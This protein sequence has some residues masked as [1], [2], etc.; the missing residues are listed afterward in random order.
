MVLAAWIRVPYLLRGK[1]GGPPFSSTY[2]NTGRAQ[3]ALG[4]LNIL[5][6][7][8]LQHY[9]NLSDF[10]FRAGHFGVPEASALQPLPAPRHYPSN[11]RERAWIYHHRRRALYWLFRQA[12]LDH[13]EAMRFYAIYGQAPN[14]I[15]TVAI[16]NLAQLTRYHLRR[17]V[18]LD[19]SRGQH[20]LR[21]ERYLAQSQAGRG[22]RASFPPGL[23]LPAELLERAAAETAA[24][25]GEVVTP[26]SGIS[27]FIALSL[28]HI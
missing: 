2:G 24:L 11:S 25:Q 15:P 4:P 23:N 9:T 12:G 6:R 8:G 14:Y 18:Q 13:E 16:D 20:M 26:A 21:W 28:I 10:K 19:F 5:L 17:F 27:R 1:L 3:G 7:R 22:G